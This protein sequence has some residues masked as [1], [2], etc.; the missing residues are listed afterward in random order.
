MI[1]RKNFEEKFAENKNNPKEL[2]QTVKSLG[3]PSKGR[4]QSKILKENGMVSFDSKKN[5]SIFSRFFSNLADLLLQQLPHP[6]KQ[7]WIHN[8]WRVF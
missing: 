7:I 2:W 1:I 5:T 6:K 8:Q 3:M 4:R